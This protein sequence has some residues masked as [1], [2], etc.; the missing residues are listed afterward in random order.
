[1]QIIAFCEDF[2][3]AI[4]AS[5]QGAAVSPGT[6]VAAGEGGSPPYLIRKARFSAPQIMP[7]FED[8]L[9]KQVCGDGRAAPN[10]DGELVAFAKATAPE[11]TAAP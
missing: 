10:F 3:A 2:H 4:L 1:M 8:T 5:C 7:G 9:I 6:S 11:E